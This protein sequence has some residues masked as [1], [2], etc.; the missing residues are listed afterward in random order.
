LIKKLFILFAV[1][2]VS[3]IFFAS[4]VRKAEASTAYPVRLIIPSI[5]LDAPIQ[6]VGLNNKG[7][8]AVP[9]GTTGKVGWYEYGA[10]PGAIGSAVLDAH[11][12]AAFSKLKYLHAGSD[13][14]VVTRN[15]TAL[16]FVVS[17]TE[18][19]PL[20]RLS[21]DT[22]FNLKDAKRL[23]LITCAGTYIPALGTYDQ[24]RVAHAI[25]ADQGTLSGVGHAS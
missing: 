10:L 13:I 4:G 22:L 18:V 2:A 14:Y 11:V 9:D 7:E 20:G 17:Q 24:R 21:T 23:N 6:S 1:V 3:F 12:Y 16:H 5:G 8:M 25:L 19:S 15:N